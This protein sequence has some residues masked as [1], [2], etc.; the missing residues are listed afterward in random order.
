MSREFLLALIVVNTTLVVV[1]CTMVVVNAITIMRR[2]RAQK[3]LDEALA[4]R[5]KLR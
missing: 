2:R 5:A 3:K 4:Q 1:N